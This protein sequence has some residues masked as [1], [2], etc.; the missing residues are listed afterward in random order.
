MNWEKRT[1]SCGELRAANENETVILNGWAAR[2]RDLGGLVFIDL[3]DR[4][5]ITQLVAEP[6]A[7]AELA[8]RA[9]EVKSEYVIWAKGTVR[10]RES[11]NEHLA[12]GAVEILM[13]DFGV[14]NTAELPPFE[15]KDEID[16]NEDT[17][18]KY[19][20][21]DL[22]RHKMQKNL[23]VRNELYQATHRYFAEKSFIEIETPFLVKSTPEGA[24]DFL[25]P[26]RVYNGRF[27][28][29]PQS[30]QI[31]KQLLMTS[32]FDRYVQIVKCFRD[33][34]VRSDRQ[35]EFTQ[36]DAEMSF[37]DQDD[38][39]NITEGYLKKVWK[40]IL[41][42]D[43]EL[44][45]RRMT[46]FEAMR[47]YGSDK[48]DLRFGMELRDISDIV[49]DSGFKVFAQ[50]LERGGIVSVLNA[51]GCAK[52]YSRKKIDELTEHAKKYGAKGLAWMK[53]TDGNVNSPI[54]KFF[55]EEEINAIMEK[56]G[57]EEGDL[58]L[59]GADTFNV[60][61]TALGALR[62]KIAKD[63]GILENVKEKF[64]FTWVTDFPL[65][66]YDDEEQ[67]WFAMHHPFTAP[68]EEDID[69]LDGAPEKALS[70]AYDITVNGAE[71]G[72][73]S[74]RIHDGGVQKKMFKALGMSE[75]EAK[76]KFGFLLEALKYGAPPHGGIAFGL[77]RMVMILA[78]IDNI[79]DTIAFP[80]TTT[81]L[82]LMD[83]APAEVDEKQL[84]ELGLAMVKKNEK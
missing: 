39:M 84:E 26:S 49:R 19:R 59:F 15:I 76:F 64:E 82:S 80:K 38:V 23:E 75:E 24:R 10:R 12:T 61:C 43:I 37:V 56:A 35:A 69:L 14:I 21:L 13:T 79:R 9:K 29:L 55:K 32:G 54:A 44:P 42:V 77:D 72:G 50:A 45:L 83:G 68:R 62:L 40:D 4:E 18:L 65:F 16:L 33:E 51:K 78:G 60:C 3:R 36:V 53:L 7:N 52:E 20:F 67:R 2:V 47:K 34:D 46:Y 28:A 57:A 73:G 81:G 17:R 58:L 31:Y 22:R 8:G 1:H 48:P 74:I 5:G 6:D 11:P 30:P 25:V 66:E 70:K 63:R 27:Y 71:I 41:D